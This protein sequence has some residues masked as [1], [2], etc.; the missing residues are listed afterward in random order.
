MGQ[1]IEVISEKENKE[2]EIEKQFQ[3]RNEGRIRGPDLL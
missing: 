3:G 2:Q 1:L